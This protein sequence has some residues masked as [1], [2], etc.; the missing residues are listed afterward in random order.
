MK[1]LKQTNMNKVNVCIG[2]FSL[3]FVDAKPRFEAVQVRHLH[4]I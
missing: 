4:F 1:A 3:A 2:K